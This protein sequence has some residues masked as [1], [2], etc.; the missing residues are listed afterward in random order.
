MSNIEKL[1]KGQDLKARGS[2]CFSAGMYSRAIAYYDRMLECVDM[3]EEHSA[4]VLC[5]PF[6]IAANSTAALCLL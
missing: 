2:K 1:A 3:D 4:Y 6:K 5:K